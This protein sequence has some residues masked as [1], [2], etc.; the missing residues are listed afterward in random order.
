MALVS[1]STQFFA[2]AGKH[3]LC[4]EQV[5]ALMPVVATMQLLP[6]F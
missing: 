1:L 2:L 6:S 4:Q 3:R 5:T